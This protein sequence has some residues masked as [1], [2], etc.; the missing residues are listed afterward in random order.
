MGALLPVAFAGATVP[1]LLL[2]SYGGEAVFRTYLFALPWLAFLAARACT[3]SSAQH[4][5]L[6]VRT[7]RLIAVCAV[8]IP[9]LLLAYFGYEKANYFS[10]SDVAA[11]RWWEQHA[12]RHSALGLI[13]QNFPSRLTGKY[14]YARISLSS[15]TLTDEGG[16]RYRAIR[17]SDLR[18]I[19]RMLRHVGGRNRYLAITPSQERFSDLYGLLPP[20]SFARL[21]HLLAHSRQ[22]RL[23]YHNGQAEIYK[24]IE[25]G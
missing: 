17:R 14:A 5:R 9:C 3:P 23:V 18:R 2:Q 16:V 7:W 13:A 24:V 21:R 12:P 10:G 6:P 25:R 11:S 22:F 20:G 8:T 4:V 1:V 19:V 15:P